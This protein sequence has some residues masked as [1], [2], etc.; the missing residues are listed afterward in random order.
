[1]K[2]KITKV[3]TT[4]Y[5]RLPLDW[6]REKGIKTGDFVNLRENENGDLVIST[7]RRSS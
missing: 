3:S 2:V 5:V 6:R 1:M 7:E 4:C